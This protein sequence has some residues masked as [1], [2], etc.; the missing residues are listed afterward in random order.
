M[1]TT[2][3]RENSEDIETE[4]KQPG[5]GADPELSVFVVFT[6]IRW[7]LKAL[8]KAREIVRPAGAA[9]T[10]VIAQIVPFPLP[11]DESP[12]PLEFVVRRF[13][14]VAGTLPGKIDISAYLCRNPLE[15]YKRVFSRNCR[16]VVGVKRKWLPGRDRRLARKLR[17]AGYDVILV[18]TE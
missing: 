18:E 16:I 4:D 11:L 14:E 13:E 15:A 17:R 5:G 9:V 12:V 6:S 1:A 7:T 3:C 10:V 2:I 8:V